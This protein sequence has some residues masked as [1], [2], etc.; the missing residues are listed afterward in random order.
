MP[1][2]ALI[3]V[4]IGCSGPRLTD[5]G[6][7]RRMIARLEV[8]I[9]YGL[10]VYDFDVRYLSATTLLVCVF[11][12]SA[13]TPAGALPTWLT[14]AP[15]SA[16]SSESTMSPQVAVDSQGDA[17]AVWARSSGSGRTVEAAVR[18]AGSGAWQ[19]PVALSEAGARAERPALAVDPQGDAVVVWERSKGSGSVIEAAVRPAASGAWQRPLQL[20]TAG[21]SAHSPAV[22]IDSQ[23]NTIA[24]WTGSDGSNSIVEAAA[25]SAASGAWQ[26]PVAL[27]PAGQRA[28]APRVALDPQGD[29]VAVWQ[30]YGA[31]YIIEAAARPAAGGAWQTPVAL[32][33]A[34]E[35]SY[36]AQVAIDSQGNTIA[37]W[38]RYSS[39]GYI[40]EAAVGSVVS[41][42]WQAP[43]TLSPAGEEAYEP[44]VALDP[45]GDAVA[46][47]QSSTE[48]GESI[49]AA[50]RP[51]A[52]GAWQTPTPLSVRGMSTIGEFPEVALD[53]RGDA[54]A[55]WDRP[56]GGDY[57]VEAAVRSAASGAWQTP[58]PLSVAG[59]NAYLPQVAVDPQGN[60][61]AVWERQNPSNELIE[62]AGYDAAGPLLRSLA[63]PSAGAVGQ[64]L[65]FSVSPLDAWS[66][67]GQ[68][69][70]SFGDGSSTT[71][72]SATHTYTI[73]GRYQATVSSTDVLGN[74]TSAAG[75]IVITTPSTGPPCAC[76]EQPLLHGAH[77][78]NKRFRVSPRAT[79][80]TAGEAPVGTSFEF[81]LSLPAQLQITITRS[82]PGLR[83]RRGCLAPTPAL[84][85]R[86][87]KR[88]TRTLTLGTLTRSNEAQGADSVL[89][90]GRIGHR[91]LPPGS[92]KALLRAHN[93]DTVG[94]ATL[95]FTVVR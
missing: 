56:N 81:T 80:I 1:V 72:T 66:M 36:T 86:H 39:G 45:Q 4:D 3:Y 51:A 32:S 57:F 61:V 54:V 24:V 41:G 62:A 35:S 43:A 2:D 60:A 7:N 29:A 9:N 73:A 58:T 69:S 65:S 94:G 37:V 74:T 19:T 23:G 38:G 48:A 5:C 87:P 28:E 59:P 8:Q 78:T 85:R 31:N 67:L 17:I 93:A 6:G 33:P 64:P 82:A 15:L 55:V 88:C 13:P 46:V 53:P 75:M 27:S 25:G 79:A 21:L 70:W 47:W 52:S 77:L 10:C 89:F 22:A 16:P 44:D 50:V 90:S 68:T 11:A 63:I 71:G 84:E 95:S 76:L 42:A 14:P 83:R 40:V 18:P 92:Y 26:T 12:L 91:A 49:E 20:S 34:G 30:S